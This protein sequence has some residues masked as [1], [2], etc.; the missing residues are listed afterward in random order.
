M[1]R[2]SSE[3]PPSIEPST[4]VTSMG[5]ITLPV[6]A[7][8]DQVD[9]YL[10][11]VW[12]ETP[13]PALSQ[14][15]RHILAA[16]GKKLRPLLT[17]LSASVHTP[18]DSRAVR[19]AAAIE[20]LHAATLIHDDVIDH[21]Y[22]RRGVPTAN[23][24]WSNTLAVLSGDYLFAKCS[25]VLA[26]LGDPA[27]VRMLART[28]MRMVA[29]ETTQFS[30]IEQKDV[31]E[32]EYYVKV[33]GKTASLF[34]LCCDGGGLVGGVSTEEQEALR[35]Y[36]E[37]LGTA[38]QVVDDILDIAGSEEELG[39]PVGGDLREGTV[40]LP[41]IIFLRQSP[42]HPAVARLLKQE[43]ADEDT[44]WEAVE[45]IRQS[46]AIEIAYAKARE[47][48]EQ[49]RSAL[50]ALPSGDSRDS[51]DMLIDYVVERRQ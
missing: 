48:G 15:V 14:L 19:V 39:K 4:P 36:G 47:F 10:S 25:H 11:S 20:I 17:L 29:S 1:P 9:D 6:V 12:E 5:K 8:L 32:N 33:Q 21:A 2:R 28:V 45:A 22:V 40:T 31:L 13:N 49:A 16:G 51:L 18:A 50:T 30:D 23:S 26:E 41:S 37:N 27:L 46:G 3:S 24:V 44:V 38:F 43:A 42:A 7:G 34:E 35:S